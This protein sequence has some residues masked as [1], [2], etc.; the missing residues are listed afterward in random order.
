MS[1]LVWRTSLVAGCLADCGVHLFRIVSEVPTR[2]PAAEPMPAE[3]E[4]ESVSGLGNNT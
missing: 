4:S 1:H 3:V 2:R